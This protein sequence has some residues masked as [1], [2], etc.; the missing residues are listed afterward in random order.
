M[1]RPEL[2]LRNRSAR[3]T[4]F[5]VVAAASWLTLEQRLN[6]TGVSASKAAASAPAEQSPAAPL[7]EPNKSALLVQQ[8][9]ENVRDA[10][11]E[12]RFAFQTERLAGAAREVEERIARLDARSNELKQWLS[13]RDEFSRL[14][15]NQ[16]VGIFSTMRPEPASEQ[17]VRLNHTTAAAILSKLEQRAASAILN[18][19]PPD[20][21]ARLTSIMAEAAQ[22]NDG[23]GR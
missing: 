18:E 16:L 17:L 5:A 3:V 10:A 4:L 15:T 2:V 21:A 14:A 12:A 7:S 22:K 23:S 6:A 1:P 9:C 13:R 19:M 11:A 20:K 8:Y